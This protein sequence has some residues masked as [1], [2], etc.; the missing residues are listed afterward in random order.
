MPTCGQGEEEQEDLDE[1][2]RVADH[3]DVDGGELADDRDAVRARGAERDPDHERAGDRDRRDLERVDEPVRE[4]VAVLGDEPPSRRR[5][6]V[7]VS[8]MSGRL[9]RPLRRPLPS[10]DA[11]GHTVSTSGI[12][13]R[14]VVEECCSAAGCSSR[15]R[16]R[17]AAGRWPSGSEGT[18][19][20]PSSSRA[21][22]RPT[23]SS[24][25]LPCFMPMPNGSGEED[26]VRD[27]Q[28]ADRRPRSGT[29]TASSY[30][31]ASARPW[32]KASIAF[33]K[34]SVTIT[35]VLLKQFFIHRS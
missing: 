33:V 26:V 30:M 32:L 5:A 7:S 20:S 19:P 11:Y 27:L 13:G 29:S 35:C 10:A 16:S 21:A 28:R 9:R 17:T 3:L 31:S 4:L 23:A 2:R 22:S 1:D 12:A 6:S 24:R 34:L 18:G 25:S 14:R 8:A 15:T